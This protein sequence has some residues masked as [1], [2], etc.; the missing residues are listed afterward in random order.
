[1]RVPFKRGFIFREKDLRFS[2]NIAALEY[3]TEEVL[4]C[5]LWEIKD[6]SPYDINVAILY[7]AY[8]QACREQ[9]RKPKYKLSDAMFWME[10]MSKTSRDEFMRSCQKLLGKL[11]GN[12][13]DEEKKK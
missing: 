12:K 13:G 10:H 7:G 11:R 2:F 9:Y 3:A 5:D 6:K 4:K 8:I 1:M